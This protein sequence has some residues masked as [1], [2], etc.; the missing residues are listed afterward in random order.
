[1]TQQHLQQQFPIQGMHCAACS[2]RIEKVV[3]AFHKHAELHDWFCIVHGAA[4]FVLVDDRK[5]GPTYRKSDVATL[6]DKSP[7]LLV[8]PPGVYH[9]WMSLAPDT[10]LL[11]TASHVYNKTKPDEE[12]IPPDAFDGLL[13]GS[14][15]AILAK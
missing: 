10:M 12:R 9:G 1:M 8:V 3:R 5:G 6:S 7:K 4:K 15:W 2:A 14:P 13:G 11:S